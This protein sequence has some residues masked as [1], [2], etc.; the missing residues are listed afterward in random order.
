MVNKTREPQRLNIKH[1]TALTVKKSGYTPEEVRDV[2][3]VFY[4]TMREQLYLGNSILFERLFKVEIIKPEPKRIRDLK[5]GKIVMSAAH[6]RPKLT[7]SR[8][9]LDYIRAQEGTVLKVKRGTA[10]RRLQ[11]HK[12]T[13]QGDYYV[14]KEKLIQDEFPLPR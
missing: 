6:P 8:G 14:K 10:S 13:E 3:E 2:L 9:L 7:P 12:H 5:T 4:D 11:H 1:M